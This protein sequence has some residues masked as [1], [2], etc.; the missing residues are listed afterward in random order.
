M[1]KISFLIVILTCG[2]AFAADKY[3]DAGGSDTRW[4]NKYNWQGDILPAGSD[5][6]FFDVVG[7]SIL[8]EP[9]DTIS[10]YK[11]MG[12][13]YSVAATVTMTVTGGSLS[14]PSYWYIGNKAGGTG[15]LNVQG[16][17]VTTRDLYL[18]AGDGCIG[19]IN[20]SS[21]LLDITGST[22]GLG[23]FFGSTAAG[24]TNGSA[25]ISI[26]G[27]TL[28]IA[29]FN[30]LGNYASINIAGGQMV[31]ANDQRTVISNY[32]SAGKIKGYGSSSRVGIDYDNINPG[33]TTVYGTTGIQSAIAAA[34]AGAIIYVP[35]GT[36]DEGQFNIDKAVTLKSVEGPQATTINL[37]GNGMCHVSSNIVVDGFTIKNSGA[38][39]TYLVRIGKSIAEVAAAVN[40]CTIQNCVIDCGN[41]TDGITVYSDANDIDIFS[42]TVSN[43][44]NGLVVY[45]NA[46]D[47]SIVDNDLFHNSCGLRT[48]GSVDKIKLLSNGIYWNTAYGVY[49]NTTT[50]LNAE[51]NYWGSENGP[52]NVTSNPYGTGNPVSNYVD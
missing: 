36:Y 17:T 24:P 8:I 4:L 31:I 40:R 20:I 19:F 32:V 25:S 38:S 9:G 10:A 15:I 33:M 7:S 14:N 30:T 42:N 37:S 35:A 44:V 34:S 29:N 5:R 2:A 26:T 3:W 6:V 48:L 23:A 22:S 52:Y 21:G 18:G 50:T 11:I 12:P 45:S 1:K 49:N 28:K 41:L 47:I 13:C 27:G 43:C 39:L 46:K 16:G 51:N